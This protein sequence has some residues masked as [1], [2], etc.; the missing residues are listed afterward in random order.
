M[1]RIKL[2]LIGLA[3]TSLI[4]LSSCEDAG[5]TRQRLYGNEA[6]LPDELKGL[7]VYSV[8]IGD[9]DFIRVG[10]LNGKV[11]STTYT[12]GK[13]TES[14]VELQVNDGSNRIIQVSS[15]ISENDSIIVVRK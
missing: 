3:S 13:Q 10:I 14:V 9:G 1:K 4:T 7:K 8:S 6:N 11:N 5:V 2:L 15:I 12:S